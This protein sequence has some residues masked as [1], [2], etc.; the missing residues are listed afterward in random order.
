MSSNSKEQH[1]I[2][3]HE[4]IFFKM[5]LKKDPI[6]CYLNWIQVKYMFINNI[7]SKAIK[8]VL[9]E[10]FL[11]FMFYSIRASYKLRFPRSVATL[12]NL[13]GKKWHAL[14]WLL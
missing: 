5:A 12:L 13:P 2:K 10:I 9:N 14:E 8:F 11:F 1:D 3:Q 6:K 7:I 4:G